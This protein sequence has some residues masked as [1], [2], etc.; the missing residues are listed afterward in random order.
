MFLNC[1][2]LLAFLAGDMPTKAA[3]LMILFV[4]AVSSLM[5]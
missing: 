2:P 4:E 5:M 1:K 3:S